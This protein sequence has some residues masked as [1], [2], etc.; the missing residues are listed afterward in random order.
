M[1]GRRRPPAADPDRSGALS[2]PVLHSDPIR[3]IL[4]SGEGL[5]PK[6]RERRRLELRRQWTGRLIRLTL[7]L[8]DPRNLDSP[9]SLSPSFP[10]DAWL[11]AHPT[12]THP[13]S[14][15]HRYAMIMEDGT[16]LRAYSADFLVRLKWAVETVRPV[17]REFD[18]PVPAF[19]EELSRCWAGSL[20]PASYHGD[21]YVEQVILL[22]GQQHRDTYLAYTAFHEMAHARPRL[23]CPRP[24]E[25]YF[26]HLE[27]FQIRFGLILKRFL[28]TDTSMREAQRRFLRSYAWEDDYGRPLH[29][30]PERGWQGDSNGR[31]IHCPHPTWDP[32]SEWSREDW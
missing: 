1:S 10:W 29:P 15:H 24:V 19:Y 11:A 9:V 25:D 21:A 8:R 31:W 18:I 4:V 28:E 32:S 30:G 6:E 27:P 14:R 5:P 23:E 13:E 26:A 7:E 22:S 16:L 20:K 3:P 17:M 12:W 2:P